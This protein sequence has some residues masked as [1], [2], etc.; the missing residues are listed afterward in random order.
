[1]TNRVYNFCAGPCTL[2]LEVLE[3]AQKEFVDF[4]N[5]GMSLIEMSHRAP[6]YDAIHHE[7]MEL[8]RDLYKVPDDFAVLFLQGG[9]TL[10]FSMVPMNLLQPGQKAAYVG[11]G[12][13]ASGAFA[14]AQ[15]YGDAYLAWDGKDEGYTRMPASNEIELQPDT[16]YLHI[17]SNETIGGIRMTEWPEVD[18]PLIGDMSSD[19]MSRFIPWEK[20]DLVYGG[21]QKNLG[22]AGAALVFVRKSVLTDCNTDIGEYLRYSVH[23]EKNSLFNTPPVFTIYMIGK[24]LKWMKAKGGLKVIEQE[25]ARKAG[26]LYDVIDGSNGWYSCPVATENRSHMNVVFRL[27]SEELEKKFIKEA[28]AAGMKNLKG[29]RSVGGCRASIYNAM[30]YEG[31]DA[32]AQFMER[33][34]R[35]NG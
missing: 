16:R 32:L 33:F 14:D 2:P 34:Q 1:M 29:H 15:K 19:Y 21:A 9:A 22:P 3:E 28:D 24:V 18:V 13:W 31:V 30:P 27:P 11:S 12:S 10:Q 25:A 17:T 5:T 8:A 26:R 4:Q 20:F 6:E 23:A 35:D 7:A